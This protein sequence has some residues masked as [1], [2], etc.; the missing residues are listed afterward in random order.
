MMGPGI[1]PRFSIVTPSWNSAQFIEATLDSVRRQTYPMH[2]HIV[3]DGK[4]T[5]GT[6]AILA[7]RTDVVWLREAD[8]GQAD[9]INRGFRQARGEI[10]AWQNADDTYE[11]GLWRSSPSTSRVILRWVSCTAI[12]R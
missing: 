8:S 4:S 5:D 1:P 6:H 9:A 10:L 7:R 3:V 11:P 2:E 12:T